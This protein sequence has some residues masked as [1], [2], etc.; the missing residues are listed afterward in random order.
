MSFIQRELD[1]VSSALR[2]ATPE[3][4]EKLYV[5][6]QALSWATDPDMFKS[7]FNLITGG[8]AEAAVMGKPDTE[9]A[10]ELKAED[11]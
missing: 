8:R 10:V 3:I 9:A 7:P 2:S 6:Q 1:R 11:L 5:A 4:Y